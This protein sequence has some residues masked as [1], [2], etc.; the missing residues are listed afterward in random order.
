MWALPLFLLCYLYNQGH[1]G[2]LPLTVAARLSL[3]G[4]NFLM[5]A[6][7]HRC[8]RDY[9]RV[10][11][12]CPKPPT[13]FARNFLQQLMKV[14]PLVL[15]FFVSFSQPASTFVFV[16]MMPILNCWLLLWRRVRVDYSFSRSNP[17]PILRHTSEEVRFLNVIKHY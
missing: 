16:S 3:P 14:R 9:N 15:I 4:A 10:A 7:V 2:F 12:A 6:I 1:K 13:F 8:V 5:Y 17:V 11:F